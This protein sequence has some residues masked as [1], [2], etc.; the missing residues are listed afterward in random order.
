MVENRLRAKGQFAPS[1]IY[2]LLMRGVVVYVGKSLNVYARVGNHYQ[3]MARI[4]KGMRPYRDWQSS[5]SMTEWPL[6][7]EVQ[8]FFAA[9]RELDK[10]ELEYIQRYMPQHNKLLKRAPQ[11]IR[12]SPAVQRLLAQAEARKNAELRRRLP[13]EVKKVEDFFKRERDRRMP[14]TLPHVKC[15]EETDAA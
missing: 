2:L 10:L 1:G 9:P 8:F 12:Q 3:N 11:D 15:L 7:D 6:F 5:L 13:S 4:R 14:I